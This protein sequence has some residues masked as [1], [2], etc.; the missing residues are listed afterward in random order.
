MAGSEAL[1]ASQINGGGCL[2]PP[3]P[4]ERPGDVMS[5]TLNAFFGSETR[6]AYEKY[7]KELDP[8]LAFR[9]STL[10]SMV[11]GVGGF[12]DPSDMQ[13]HERPRG[14]D[15]DAVEGVCARRFSCL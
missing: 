6:T 2:A 10:K 8:S 14:T 12:I 4:A 7:N 13:A 1:L 11:S 9:T 3:T 15:S 5:K